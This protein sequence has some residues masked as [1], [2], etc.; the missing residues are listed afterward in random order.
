MRK[1]ILCLFF[2]TLSAA[3]YCG[4]LSRI[5]LADGSVINGEI[6]SFLNGIYTVNTGS[7]GEVKLEAA[8]ISQIKTANSP[9]FNIPSSIPVQGQ[10]FSQPNVESYRQ[11]LMSDP[12]NA[13]VVSGLVS[14]PHIQEI[15]KDPQIEQAVKAGDMQALMNNPKFMEMVNSPEMQEGIKKL[16]KE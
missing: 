10:T 11:K 7:L 9:S 13:A 2:L 4:Q 8:K 5:E 3:A 14:N 16:K 6:V 12:D 1:T 15:A